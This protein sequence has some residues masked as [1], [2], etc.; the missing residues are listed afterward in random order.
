MTTTKLNA[1]TIAAL[2]LMA[3]VQSCKKYGEGPA[4]TFKS[5]DSRLVGKWDLTGGDYFNPDND[6]SFEF[7]KDGDFT[8][9]FT[10]SYYGYSYSYS[11][12][13][14]WEWM[15]NKKDLLTD[16]D[17]DLKKFSIEMLTS[18]EMKLEDSDGYDF[19]FVK[20]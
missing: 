9:D 17:G 2:S 1:T 3:S 11:D 19:E 4:L 20:Q 18:T 10:Y 12:T 14:N 13:G 16:T 5:A 7:E 6:I 8:L 15:N